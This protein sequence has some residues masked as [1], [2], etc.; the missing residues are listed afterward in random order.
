[1]VPLEGVVIS[2]LQLRLSSC[3]LKIDFDEAFKQQ[4]VGET[5]A[6]ASA[7]AVNSTAQ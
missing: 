1:M 4:E 3:G 2:S 6:L 7:A 5:K